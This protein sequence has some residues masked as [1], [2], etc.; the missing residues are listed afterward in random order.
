MRR[1]KAIR[2]ALFKLR[3]E[4]DFRHQH[5]RLA[6]GLQHAVNDLQV[7]LGFAAAGHAMKK[8]RGQGVEGFANGFD[9]RLL[10]GFQGV[11]AFGA[12]RRIAAGFSDQAFIDERIERAAGRTGCRAQ[13]RFGQHIV[14]GQH[15]HQASSNGVAA[16]GAQHLAA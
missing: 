9:R 3:H 2:H 7:H 14:L 5:Q 8:M 10:R 15:L 6:A 1:G 16:R 13:V 12:R 11:A 4:R